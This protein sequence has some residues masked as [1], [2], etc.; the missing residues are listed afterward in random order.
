MVAVT[1]PLGAMDAARERADAECLS[2]AEWVRRAV[3]EKLGQTPA[4]S[5]S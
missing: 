4:S 3:A 1:L 5:G 2:V